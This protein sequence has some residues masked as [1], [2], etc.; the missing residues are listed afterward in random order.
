MK[1]VQYFYSKILLPFDS[2]THAE[3]K[4]AA[5]DEQRQIE[6][7]LL[8]HRPRPRPLDDLLADDAALHRRRQGEEHR[9]LR[10]LERHLDSTLAQLAPVLGVDLLCLGKLRVQQHLDAEVGRSG[11]GSIS[12]IVSVRFTTSPVPHNVVPLVCHM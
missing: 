1:E 4:R 6:Q 7:E 2:V 5:I 11:G 8:V 12:G 3:V 9:R 10:P